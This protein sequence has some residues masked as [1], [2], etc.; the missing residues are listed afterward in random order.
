M[1]AMTQLLSADTNYLLE[2]RDKVHSTEQYDRG[3]Q[4]GWYE[5]VH[6]D[7]P[8]EPEFPNRISTKDYKNTNTT[9]MKDIFPLVM[10][11]PNLLQT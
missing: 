6:R 7:S 5:E 11:T 3:Q 9:F 2:D 1:K 4:M 8:L 10:E